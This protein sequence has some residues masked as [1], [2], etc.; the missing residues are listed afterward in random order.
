MLNVSNTIIKFIALYSTSKK[1]YLFSPT[2][3][4]N[5]NSSVPLPPLIFTLLSKCREH[6]T[7]LCGRYVL[8]LFVWWWCL[9]TAFA[10]ADSQ[11]LY[12]VSLADKKDT[13]FSLLQP[14]A[15]LSPRA[16]ERRAN[17]GIA[18]SESDLP[19]NPDYIYQVKACGATVRYQSKWLNSLTVVAD[20]FAVSKIKKLPFVI[21]VEYV[22]VYAKPT[23][24]ELMKRSKKKKYQK[25]EEYYG[26][27]DHQIRMLNGQALHQFGFRGKDKLIAVLDGGFRGVNANPFYDTLR[28][29][30]RLLPGKDFVDMDD[31]V[32]ESSGHGAQV[33]SCMAA[34]IPGLYIGSAPDAAYTC[35]KTEDT[36][37]EFLIEEC[38]WVAGAEYAD[39]IGADI[40]NSSLGYTSFNDTTMNYTYADLNGQVSRASR[41]ADIAFAKGMIV[42][43][44]AGNSGNDSWKY[45]GTP[46]DGMFTLAVGATDFM[47]N[48]ASFSS[49]GPTADGRIKPNVSAMGQNIAVVVAG[50]GYGVSLSNGTSFASPLLAGMLASLWSALPDYNNTEIFQIVQMAG[51]NFPDP[52]VEL[53]YGIPDFLGA[54][55]QETVARNV[56][57]LSGNEF[58]AVVP[59]ASQVLHLILVPDEVTPAQVT[60]TNAYGAV[61][62]TG[63][64]NSPNTNELL[65]EAIPESK[66]WADGLYTLEMNRNG[67]LQK[68]ILALHDRER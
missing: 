48:R 53:G 43:N 21:Q 62:W 3:S 32:Y 37:G 46:A 45:I 20:S 26:F 44:S 16:I 29:Y 25:T 34:Q 38:N 1:I 52:D 36:R 4:P 54:F 13:P 63:T 51:S 31:D 33:L 14:E 2:L 10:K 35:I 18:L 24:E 27:S 42:V 66:E 60:I 12:W 6:P 17:Q 40:I 49:F 30:D 64:V 56:L 47:G 7:L 67:N 41:A 50:T 19:V 8:L 39:S 9:G 23:R 68:I 58:V 22:G 5:H 59:R 65:I 55:L 57:Y 61:V 28:M 11:A 15:F